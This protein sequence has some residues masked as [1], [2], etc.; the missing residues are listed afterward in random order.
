MPRHFAQTPDGL[1]LT[2][3]G[4]GRV[5]AW[6]GFNPEAVV[7]GIDAPTTAPTVSSS[8]SGGISG[9]YYAYVRFV[10]K[11]GNVSDLS[12]ISSGVTV[13]DAS[14]ILYTNV[15]ISL[16]E[17]VARRQILRNTNGQTSVFYVDKDT[18][19]LTS[20]NF[21]SAKTDDLLSTQE[22]VTLLAADGSALANRHAPPPNSKPFLAYH[23]GRMFLAGAETYSE[24][25]AKVVFGSATVTGRGTNW[26]TTLA[27]RRFA[28]KGADKPYLVS[29]VESATSLTLSVA[30]TGVASNY[31]SYTIRPLPAECRN[32]AYSEPGL[33]ESWPATNGFTIPEDG[34][35]I[36]GLL[37]MG[38]FLYTLER[39]HIY[40]FTFQNDPATDGYNFLS[41]DRGCVNNRCHVVVEENAYMLDDRGIHRF[42]GDEPQPI[43][44]PIQEL[45]RAGGRTPSR[46][47]WSTSRWW[48]AAHD[49]AAEVIRWFVGLGGTKYPR[50]AVCYAYRAERW[51]LEE[52]PR[53]VGASC[54]GPLGG[55]TGPVQVFLG[56]EARRF[57]A[58]R[59]GQLDLTRAGSGTL[60]GTATAA[61]GLTL[62]DSA[63]NFPSDCVGAP[64]SIAAGRGKGQTNRVAAVTSS[65][66]LEL[67]SP[68]VETPDTTSRYQL[69]GFP[70]D[71]TLGWQ[72]YVESE[73]DDVRQFE[74]VFEPLT[75]TVTCDWRLFLDFDTTPH[76]WRVTT[77]SRAANGVESASGEP[78]LVCDLTRA[79]GIATKRLDGFRELYAEGRRYSSWQVRGFASADPVAFYQITLDGCVTPGE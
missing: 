54:A 71:L 59:P 38:S 37:V 62:T 57:F 61:T 14:T 8:G 33:S 28:C 18:T 46:L 68:W 51:W 76:T 47:N 48:H 26:P 3:D 58:P 31:A 15:A 11:D 40:R 74:L 78:D 20:T 65:T 2:A 9:T 50:H 23:N 64:L 43:S 67:T 4:I 30:Y 32:V 60:S 75:G 16:Q 22:A 5:L 29:S 25:A 10:D 52:Y 73:Q 34:D 55:P 39:R 66:A 13:V 36:T 70:Y 53:P 77:S 21:S 56:G 12:P 17:K 44:T 79:D 27:G 41:S 6:N 49:S 63:G 72:R 69:G 45:F 1:L 42:G 35:D 19:D 24:G 7:A